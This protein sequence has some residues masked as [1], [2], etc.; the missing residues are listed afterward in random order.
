[1]G[2]PLATSVADIT[3]V[4][5]KNQFWTMYCLELNPSPT[6][7]G[8]I[9]ITNEFR[10]DCIDFSPV[11]NQTKNNVLLTSYNTI[12]FEPSPPAIATNNFLYSSFDY[13]Q[14]NFHID[15]KSYNFEEAGFADVFYDGFL[16]FDEDLSSL[17]E[18][19]PSHTESS[20][21]W[22]PSYSELDHTYSPRTLEHLAV[23]ISPNAVS[24]PI[25][26]DKTH[27]DRANIFSTI[28]NQSI[29]N[30]RHEDTELASII[31]R[32][33]SV[34]SS[35]SCEEIS[36]GQD[37][38]KIIGLS[39]MYKNKQEIFEEILRECEHNFSGDSEIEDRS[40]D[41]VISVDLLSLPDYDA[42]SETGYYDNDSVSSP[43]R[44]S[45]SSPDDATADPTTTNAKKRH[46]NRQA[47]SRYRQKRHAQRVTMSNERRRLE[48]ANAKLKK[49]VDSTQTEINYLRKFM[50]EI[51]NRMGLK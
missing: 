29:D 36:I 28:L 42:A 32:V 14:S 48:I 9:D 13:D 2:I 25:S 51:K 34:S 15:Q 5:A 46:Q 1:M 33:A 7:Q 35:L 39:P 50:A 21:A 40:T 27:S 20:N 37:S 41:S 45:A 16:T 47:A 3:V 44:G 49:Q 17:S 4:V 19:S 6:N 23:A 8:G 18:V 10:T 30:D 22:S 24:A 31:E 26:I 11:V 43:Q 38:L 12:F